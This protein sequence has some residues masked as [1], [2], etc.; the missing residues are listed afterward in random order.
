MNAKK[1]MAIFM[2]MLVMALI[3]AAAGISDKQTPQ[4]NDMGRTWIWGIICC[5]K[6]TNYH[7]SFRCIMVRF[8]TVGILEHYSG[9]LHALEKIDLKHG[10]LTGYCSAHLIMG[11]FAG[12]LVVH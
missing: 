7:F 9:G 1:I 4:T 5:Y 8:T 6:G 11:N 3:P 10:L 2:C 12:E